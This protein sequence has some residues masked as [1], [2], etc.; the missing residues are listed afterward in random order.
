[1]MEQAWG[2]AEDDTS[3]EYT[4]KVREIVKLLR[5]RLITVSNGHQEE[6]KLR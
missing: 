1:M 2:I 3:K 4:D 6:F 5:Q